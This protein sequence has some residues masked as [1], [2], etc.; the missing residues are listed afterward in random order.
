MRF[1]H[2]FVEKKRSFVVQK[3]S[4]PGFFKDEYEK[5][6]KEIPK[7][8]IVFHLAILKGRAVACF[9]VFNSPN[10]SLDYYP[11]FVEFRNIILQNK[12]EAGNPMYKV[13]KKGGY[14][15]FVY[16]FE[17]DVRVM[18]LR[19]EKSVSIVKYENH[20]LMKK[21]EQNQTAFS[22]IG[23]QEFIRNYDLPAYVG[24]YWPVSSFDMLSTDADMLKMPEEGQVWQDP[25][26]TSQRDMLEIFCM[27]K[28][29]KSSQDTP[30]PTELSPSTPDLLPPFH[31]KHNEGLFEK[32]ADGILDTDYF[33]DYTPLIN[34][35]LCKSTLE[36]LGIDTT[37]K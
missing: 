22:C 10:P 19:L 7:D 31:F 18:L 14:W 25:Y 5:Y 3:S 16:C 27:D 13:M 24:A 6:S 36:K 15:M 11:Q 30:E 4:Y 12:G 29:P 28:T 35:W 17:R 37:L 20:A 26:S 33:V 1:C 23:F 32:E 2:D 21:Y 34:Q 9:V 8:M